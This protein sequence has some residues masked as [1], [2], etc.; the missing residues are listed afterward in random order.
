MLRDVYRTA[1]SRAAQRTIIYGT[2]LALGSAILYGVAVI[3][4]IGFYRDY[5]PHRVRTA[6][7]YLQYGSVAGPDGLFPSRLPTC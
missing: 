5:V 2:L 7:L 3:G 4:Y 6:P 1:T